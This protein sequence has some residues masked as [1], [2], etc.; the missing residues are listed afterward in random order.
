MFSLLGA[1]PKFR[2]ATIGFIMSVCLSVRMEQLV[3]H[4]QDFH[5]V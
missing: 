4:W 2:K 3:F 1:L 5:E